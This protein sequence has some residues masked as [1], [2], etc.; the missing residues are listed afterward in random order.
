MIIIPSKLCKQ[1]SMT[2]LSCPQSSRHRLGNYALVTRASAGVGTVY[3][4]AALPKDV[5]DSFLSFDTLVPSRTRHQQKR[6]PSTRCVASR[7]QLVQAL[8]CVYFKGTYLV[9]TLRHPRQGV[10]CRLDTPSPKSCHRNGLPYRHLQHCQC[11]L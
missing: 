11:L 7:E 3:T 10:A 8:F 4:A 6:L 1:C 2:L 9:L 5:A